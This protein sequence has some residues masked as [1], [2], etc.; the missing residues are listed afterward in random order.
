VVIVGS[1]PIKVSK[2]IDSSSLLFGT[3]S[4]MFFNSDILFLLP[5]IIM[6]L[7]HQFGI[8]VVAVVILSQL[9]LFVLKWNI[10]HQVS[11]H[12]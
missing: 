2:T 9:V 10:I 8:G 5:L 3:S 6:W 4:R 12:F 7:L 1:L 11:N